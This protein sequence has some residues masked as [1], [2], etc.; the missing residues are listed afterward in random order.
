MPGHYEMSD[1][2]EFENR[3]RDSSLA[4]LRL[5][6]STLE[7][8]NATL[9]KERDE[10]QGWAADWHRVCQTIATIL[11]LPEPDGDFA[12]A[13]RARAEASEALVAKLREVLE[14]SRLPLQQAAVCLDGIVCLDDDEDLGK[15]GGSASCQA[16]MRVINSAVKRID[17]ALNPE[18]DKP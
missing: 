6:L 5:R 11:G 12:V 15:D 10:A 13:V 3:E 17:A 18:G 4:S 8:E 9:R 7:A 2:T 1:Y 16:V 14:K